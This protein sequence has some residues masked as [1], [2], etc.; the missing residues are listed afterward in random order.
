MSGQ[1]ATPATTRT[2]QEPIYERPKAPRKR[3][4]PPTVSVSRKSLLV[5]YRQAGEAIPAGPQCPKCG[6][7]VHAGERH[8]PAGRRKAAFLFTAMVHKA[9]HDWIHAHPKD[10]EAVGLLWSGRNSKVLTLAAA[11]ELVL[12]QKFPAFYSIDI[13]K[14]FSLTK[15]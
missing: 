2:D 1:T 14:A 8:H 11:T 6:L 15:P 5:A 4:K 10:A 9:C 3:R 7:P 13:L 12:K